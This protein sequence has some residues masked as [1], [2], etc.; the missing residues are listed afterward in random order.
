MDPKL[1]YWTAALVNL[2]VL[3]AY[4]VQGV[5]H[6]RRGEVAR[7]RRNMTIASYLVL[8]FLGSYVLKLL[9]LG[10][11]DMA[12]WS[13]LDVWILRIHEVFVLL[14]VGAGILAWWQARKLLPTRLVTRDPADPAPDPRAA[15]I[16]RVA[17]RTAVVGA[18][19]GFLL[20]IGVLLGMYVRAYA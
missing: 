5:R 14:M 12:I 19:L 3:C 11:E 13:T 8:A 1:L 7:H 10:R 17:G 16:H 2:A 18:L 4:A 6:V 9:F 20:A 15:K